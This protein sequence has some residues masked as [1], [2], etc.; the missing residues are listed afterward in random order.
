MDK[1]QV[2]QGLEE[3]AVYLEIKGENPFKIAA[4]RKAALALEQDERTLDQIE[5]PQKLT[6]IGQGTAV[7]IREFKELGY[8]P[9]LE[10]LKAEIPA[11]LIQLLTL[12][13]LVARKLDGC[14]EN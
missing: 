3:I 12:P 8:A 10:E 13:A 6:G 2:I 14:T 7:V 1:K 5:D 4:Y 11:N 9:I